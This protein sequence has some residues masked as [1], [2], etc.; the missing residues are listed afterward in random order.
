MEWEGRKTQM[1]LGK[2]KKKGVGQEQLFREEGGQVKRRPL[3]SK[4]TTETE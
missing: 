3:E 2:K 4:P 1:T